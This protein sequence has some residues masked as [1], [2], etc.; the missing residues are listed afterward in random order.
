MA[1]ESTKKSKA[2]DSPGQ[3][4]PE[5]IQAEIEATREE[6]G[7]TVAEIAEKTD[8]KKQAKRKVNEAKAKATAKKDEVIEKA[9]AKKD[10]RGRQSERGRA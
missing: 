8:V 6:L 3:R 2:D 10:E 7:E 5:E 4:S 1:T 9:T